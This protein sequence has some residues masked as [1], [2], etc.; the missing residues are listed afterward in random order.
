MLARFVTA[1]LAVLIGV[2]GWQSA[3]FA[4]GQTDQWVDDD[5]VGVSAV[6]DNDAGGTHGTGDARH[7]ASAP[8]CSYDML[9]DDDAASADDFSKS[10]VGPQKGD[11]P[12]AWYRQ[13]CTYPNGSTTGI[14]VWRAQVVDPAALARQALDYSTIP[15]P[16]LALNPSNDQTQLVNLPVWLAVTGE[17]WKPVSASASADGVSVTTTAAP[18]KVVWN[19]GDGNAVTCSGPGAVYNPSLPD[20]S[21]HSDCTYIYRTSSSGQPNNAFTITATEQYHVTWVATGVP[22]GTPAAGDLG[23]ITKVSTLTV[24]VGELQALNQGN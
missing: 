23:V 12:G 14:V 9:T 15:V 1:A 18:T 8:V 17:T 16:Q 19:M 4:G 7:D 10:G 2:L 11:G 6:S 24:H 22:A 20:T 5:G 21:Q 13:I 3:A